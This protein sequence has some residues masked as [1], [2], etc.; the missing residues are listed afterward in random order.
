M[1]AVAQGWPGMETTWVKGLALPLTIGEP[2]TNYLISLCLSFL[3]CKVEMIE[4]VLTSQALGKILQINVCEVLSP[5]LVQ[6]KR[7]DVDVGNHDHC[8]CLSSLLA[9]P[10]FR[11]APPMDA[12]LNECDLPYYSRLSLHPIVH[13]SCQREASQASAALLAL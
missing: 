8:I 6:I 9:L 13:T 12:H 1:P 3:M 7:D 5:D 10:Q 2:W 4:M 11:P